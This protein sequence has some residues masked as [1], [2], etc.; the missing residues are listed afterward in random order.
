[1][2]ITVLV[3]HYK[4]HFAQQLSVSRPEHVLGQ[5]TFL[6][7]LWSFDS[8]G[9]KPIRHPLSVFWSCPAAY[10]EIAYAGDTGG[11]VLQ[12]THGDRFIISAKQVSFD[13]ECFVVRRDF[14]K[15]IA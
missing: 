4:R 8:I 5:I 11:A 10:R 3:G 1:M 14:S 13:L 7:L 12:R 15:E 2:F 9:K 6:L